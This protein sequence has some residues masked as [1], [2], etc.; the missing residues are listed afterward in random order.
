M[1]R[2]LCLLIC[3]ILCFSFAACQGKQDTE[4]AEP[5]EPTSNGTD[6]SAVFNTKKNLYFDD[7]GKF[8]VMIFSDLRMPKTGDDQ[9]VANM[10]RLLDQERPD[11]VILGGD[12]HDGTVANE[13]ELRVVL[14]ALNA[15]LEERQIPWCHAFGVNTEG[16]EKVK[17]GFS[18]E[19]QM[20]VYQS[21]SYCLSVSD[22]ANTYGVSN[23]VLPIRIDDKDNDASND[24][25]GF[26]VWLMDSNGYLNDYQD[27]LESQVVLKNTIGGNTNLDSLHY[28]QVLWYY[29]TS[30]ALEAYNG[31]RTLGMMYMQV[32]VMQFNIVKN[33]PKKTLFAGNDSAAAT[34]ISA[35]ERESGIFYTCTERGDVR[36]IFSGYNVANDFSGKYMNVTLGFCSTIGET[37]V[38][39][40]AGARVV[41]ISGRGTKM[42]T[43]MAYLNQ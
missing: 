32:P 1:K 30:V 2:I 33:N 9:I 29:D 20:K 24:K 36:G 26:F 21:Y 7:L 17:T 14:D 42:E 27:Q 35:S 3:L 43:Y 41:S 11:L 23:Y 15:P 19:A 28:S 18:R 34:E 12:V 4:Q 39:E 6:P 31:K 10:E 38:S 16:T 40:T 22:G 37:T 13:T 5:A 25:A 8:K